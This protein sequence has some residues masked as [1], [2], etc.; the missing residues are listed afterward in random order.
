V[1]TAAV[2]GARE[3]FRRREHD[4]EDALARLDAE[5]V[6]ESGELHRRMADALARVAAGDALSG[7]TAVGLLPEA[8]AREATRALSAPDDALTRR[9][10]E[11]VPPAVT[12][13]A[14][15]TPARAA[16]LASRARA[17]GGSEACVPR[18]RDHTRRRGES[19]GRRAQHVVRSASPTARA[20]SLV[21]AR[22]EGLGS[23]AGLAQLAAQRSRGYMSLWRLT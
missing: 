10:A 23:V 12:S 4:A 20:A 2:E 8:V 15:P 3:V 13:H 7:L 9:R 1:H 22:R 21:G 17:V 16:V 19:R 5:Q 18:W 11:P 6:T 14:P